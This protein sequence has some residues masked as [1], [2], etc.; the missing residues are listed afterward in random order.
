[1]IDAATSWNFMLA[2]EELFAAGRRNDD[3]V[4]LC[5]LAKALGKD[6]MDAFYEQK[7]HH[8]SNDLRRAIKVDNDFTTAQ[9][10][11]MDR[12]MRYVDDWYC[13]AGES[14]ADEFG[15]LSSGY[16]VDAK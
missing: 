3:A 9:V 8:M 4:N 10:E 14:I 6:P 5:C 12:V 16:M 11:H 1:M 13:I 15:I 2:D 7:I